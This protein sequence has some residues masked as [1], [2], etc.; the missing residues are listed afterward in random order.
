[1]DVMQHPHD[2]YVVEKSPVINPD[3]SLSFIQSFQK[4]QSE[5]LISWRASNDESEER[6]LC[7]PRLLKADTKCTDRCETNNTLTQKPTLNTFISETPS[8]P[9]LTSSIGFIPE[10]L[11][12][13]GAI[14][15]STLSRPATYLFNIN[16]SFLLG[17]TNCG[18]PLRYDHIDD[19]PHFCPPTRKNPGKCASS[20]GS[21]GCRARV[22]ELTTTTTTPTIGISRDAM[23]V[24]IAGGGGG[25]G[26]GG[27]SE[28]RA[29]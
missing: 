5:P 14:P 20:I 3:V 9:L 24:L 28:A 23:E 16:V 2:I 26:G 6:Q 12:A 7:S 29:C 25:G 22:P 27:G 17:G 10:L 13:T 18:C 21:L 1:M 4:F 15:D 11:Q 19:V 8:P